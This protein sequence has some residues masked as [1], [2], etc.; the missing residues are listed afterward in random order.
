MSTAKKAV[1]INGGNGNDYITGSA[2]NDTLNGDKG[3]DKIFGGDGKDKINGGAGHDLINGGAGKD[4]IKGGS[5]D[6]NIWISDSY[7]YDEETDTDT[8]I[9]GE[10]TLILNNGDGNDVVDAFNNDVTLK[11]NDT[12]LSEFILEKCG[13]SLLIK[14]NNGEVSVL[15]TDYFDSDSYDD[16]DDEDE[17]DLN[18]GD[19]DGEEDD[20]DDD[21]EDEEE[22][23]DDEDD[24]DLYEDDDEDEDEDE[25]DWGDEDDEDDTNPSTYIIEDKDGNKVSLDSLVESYGEIPESDYSDELEVYNFEYII[26]KNYGN[27]ICE[28]VAGWASGK[29]GY[30][31]TPQITTCG[32]ETN[33]NNL[34]AVFRNT[35]WQQL[36]F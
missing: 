33:M 6:D 25:D 14:Y 24:D 16:E 17:N 22:D 5:G 28:N 4:T 10:H 11:F 32:G 9:R 36:E 2:Y 31:G 35:G 7:V 18:D 29:D 3:N 13:D 23:E 8:N 15:I 26:S 20:G 27:Q 30:Q 1:K 12:A 19:D 34:I 21:W